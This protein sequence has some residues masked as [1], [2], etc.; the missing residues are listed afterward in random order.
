MGSCQGGNE[1]RRPEGHHHFSRVKTLLKVLG[2]TEETARTGRSRTDNLFL[3]H[4]TCHERVGFSPRHAVGRG[5]DP[6]KLRRTC[7]SG[8]QTRP[9]I[10]VV[11]IAGRLPDSQAPSW[12]RPRCAGFGDAHEEPG[13]NPP[14]SRHR[15]SGPVIANEDDSCRPLLEGRHDADLGTDTAGTTHRH[16]GSRH[17]HRDLPRSLGARSL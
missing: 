13:V 7:G 15:K 3:A 14:S 17:G 16:H 1:G 2:V 10:G 8:R 5:I 12:Q 4:G 6:G 11:E 9:T